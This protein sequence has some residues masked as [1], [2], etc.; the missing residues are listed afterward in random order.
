MDN[1][2]CI[3]LNQITT[4]TPSICKIMGVK[5]PKKSTNETIDELV[6][7]CKNEIKSNISKCLLYAPDAIAYYLTVKYP[8]QFEVVE[9][10]AP[11]GVKLC[12]IFPPKTPVCFAS[13]FSGA[14]PEI[15]G[16]KLYEKPILKCD[17][18][19]DAF[20]RANKK[21]AI[22]AVEN[23]SIDLIFKERKMDYFTEKYDKEV[24]NRTIELLG[25]ADYDL[26][27]V[28]HQEYDDMVHA[29][30]PI[31]EKAIQAMNNHIN[32]F[33]QMAIAFNKYWKDFNRIITFSPDHG[34]HISMETGKGTHGNNN[35]E[36]MIIKHNFGIY[37]EIK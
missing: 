35:P 16:I 23:S 12:S 13:M 9:Q 5:K 4:I 6:N 2:V 31:S 32:S 22:V 18:I 7:Y 26:I 1:P 29:T 14:L 19:F 11:L 36:D 10:H 30:T 8:E 17:T 28:Y 27:V 25:T 37:K 3:G 33:E 34:S 15:H 20:I 21:V 24:T